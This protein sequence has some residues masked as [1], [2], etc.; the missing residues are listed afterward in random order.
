MFNKQKAKREFGRIVRMHRT[1][2]G[3]S[4]EALADAADLDRTYIGSVETGNR[5]PSLIAIWQI[6]DGLGLSLSELFHDFDF[7]DE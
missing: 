3:L 2:Q 7:T 1:R 6:A 5:N 4:Q